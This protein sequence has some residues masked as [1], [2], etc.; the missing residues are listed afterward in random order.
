MFLALALLLELEFRQKYAINIK[1][2]I[3]YE[4]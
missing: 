4:K 1:G 3:T 2:V